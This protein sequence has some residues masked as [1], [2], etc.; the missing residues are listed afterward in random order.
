[1]SLG[2]SSGGK[3]ASVA[4][5]LARKRY[6][7]AI[8]ILRAQFRDGVRDPRMRLQL[9]DVLVLAGRPGEALPILNGLADEFA[10]AGLAAR[11]VAVQK[12]LEALTP[13][14]RDAA[15]R[16]AS[17]IRRR[18]A[19]PGPPQDAADESGRSSAVTALEDGFEERFPEPP[20]DAAEDVEASK[21][22]GPSSPAASPLWSELSEREL[23]AVI[24][25]FRLVSF[26]PDDVVVSGSQRGDSAFVVAT[27]TLH[28]CVRRDGHNVVLREIGEGACF[29]QLAALAGLPRP[30]SVTAA[31]HCE[32]LELDRS[33]C[34][35]IAA[36]HPRVR[37]VLERACS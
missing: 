9:A 33:A 36:A 13:H 16:L 29:G 15:R 18:M 11:A 23:E 6:G 30:A 31:S 26:E 2:R 24:E 12:K 4:D 25:R 32:L 34:A 20:E 8:E 19:A 21:P 37:D 28:V 7:K 22:D 5:L 3:E 10:S 17:G 1:M 14:A 27:G 35:A